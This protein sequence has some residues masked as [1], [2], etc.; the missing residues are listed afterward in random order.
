MTK[1][2]SLTVS[3]YVEGVRN[4]DRTILAKTITLIESSSP[5]HTE[6]AAK[7]LKELMPHSGRSIRI[8]ITGIPGVGKS[9]FI[10]CLGSMLTKLEH[11]V[12]VMAVDPS[13]ALSGGSILGDKTRMEKLS[14]DPNAFIR[15]SPSGGTLG[16]VTRKTREAIIVCEAA[17]YDIILIETVGVGQ[18]EIAVRSMVDFFLLLML[19]GAGDDLQGIKRGIMELADLL[20]VNKADGENRLAAETL[21]GEFNKFLHYLMPATEGWTTEATAC[22]STT[23]V[24]VKEV[25]NLIES[26]KT[27]MQASGKY[28]NRRREQAKDWMNAMI[29]DRL[30]ADFNSNKA[31]KKLLPEIEAAVL[32]GE[33]SPTIAA[34]RLIDLA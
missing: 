17:G 1:R 34:K 30:L 20:V 13:S 22:S 15:P 10:E 12:A 23:G 24:G 8:G 29:E 6:Q 3:D 2:P 32:A 28:D 4:N 5:K 33:L 7:V 25:W 14:V 16:G 11:K 31:V 18:S 21:A 19:T 9:T 27:K 26:F